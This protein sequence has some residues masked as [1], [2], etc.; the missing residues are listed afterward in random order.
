V[1]YLINQKL[2]VQGYVE[3]S[4]NEPLVT[5]SFKRSTTRVGVKVLFNLSQ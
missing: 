1:S 4:V 3:R 5:N 2:R